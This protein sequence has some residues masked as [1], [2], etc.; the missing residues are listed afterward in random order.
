MFVTSPDVLQGAIW[1]I[2][3][4][5][6]T[7]FKKLEIENIWSKTFGRTTNFDLEMIRELV[8]VRVE[9]YSRYLDGRCRNQTFCLLIISQRLFDGGRK[10]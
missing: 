5:S 6:Q 2:N 8:I 4:F 9:N 10:S 7:S 3:R 1:E